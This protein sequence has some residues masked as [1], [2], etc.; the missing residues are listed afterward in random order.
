M[1]A[2]SKTPDTHFLNVDLDVYSGSNLQPLVDA[3]GKKVIALYVG[4]ERRS[5]SAHLEL[6]FF[7]NASA[8]STIRRFCTLIRALPTAER[9]R[10]DSAKTR[11]FSI[12]VQAGERPFSR[13]FRIELQTV[14]AAAELGAAIVLTVYA[15]EKTKGRKTHKITK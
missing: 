5:H 10:W 7:R 1:T 4:R 13:D 8:D 6:P 11:E 9:K 15:P 12:G 3:L 14:K 2:R